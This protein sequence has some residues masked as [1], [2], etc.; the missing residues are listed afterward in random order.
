MIS[1]FEALAVNAVPGDQLVVLTSA[2]PLMAKQWLTDGTISSYTNAKQFK[3][4][5]VRVHTIHDLYKLLNKLESLPRACLVRGRFVGQEEAQ[6]VAQ[7]EGATLQPDHVLRRGDCFADQPLHWI[8]IDVDDFKPRCHDPVSNPVEAI[9]EFISDS[10]PAPFHGASF[11][12][13]LSASAGHPSKQGTLKAHLHFWLEMPRTCA[14]LAAWARTLPGGTIDASLY[15]P[16]Q[17]HYTAA[18]LFE[19]GVTDPVPVRSGFFES[20]L[21]LD[22]VRLEIDPAIVVP[23]RDYSG[24]P[25]TDPGAKPGVIGAFCRAFKPH[26]LD[27]LLPE[28][29]T[30]SQREGHWDWKGHSKEGVFLSGCGNALISLHATAPTGTRRPSNV[31][32]FVRLHLF[33]LLDLA[34]PEG[35]RASELPSVKAMRDWIEER[36]S[37]VLEDIQYPTNSPEEDFGNLD[38]DLDLDLDLAPSDPDESVARTSG[39]SGRAPLRVWRPA[40]LRSRPPARWLV[41]GV[42]PLRGTA[43][44]VGDSNVGKSF[45]ALDLGLAVARGVPWFEREVQQGAVLYVA[46][47]G[48]YGFGRRL[49]AYGLHHDVNVDA[50]PLGIVDDGIDLRTNQIDAQRAI[51][52]ANGLEQETKTPVRLIVLDTLAR[53]LSG[54][55]ENSSTDMGHVLAMA[56]KIAQATGAVVLIVHHVGKD[57]QRGARGH[58]SFRAALDAQIMVTK[59]KDRCVIRLDKQRDGPTDL[60][61]AYRLET[62]ELDPSGDGL[63]AETSAVVVQIDHATGLD[64]APTTLTKWQSHALDAVQACHGWGSTG[65]VK[66]D[67][68]INTAEQLLLRPGITLPNTW[69]K[70]LERGLTDLI[71]EGVLDAEGAYLA[72]GFMFPASHDK[73]A[74]H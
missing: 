12:W 23:K 6:S 69:K 41:K 63:E 32:D 8:M 44:L 62:V 50:L 65:R 5:L 34:A 60:E 47:E 64:V 39:A 74:F 9:C 22:M 46:A 59:L 33:K 31:Y 56:D 4:R 71:K 70:M 28:M 25:L 36:H 72:H 40:E 3:P 15:S 43:S 21:G 20:P 11:C 2:G 24:D 73:Q 19:P 35:C 54:G 48:G 67:A 7:R 17:V 37:H 30:Q 66:R 45:C 61:M 53:M 55:D 49:E 27:R 18:P 13:A 38:L 1:E 16:V 42:L 51:A 14:E 57:Q 52:A 26:D 10:L 58:S 29:F 68:V